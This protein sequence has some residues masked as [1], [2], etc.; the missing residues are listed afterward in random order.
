M[1]RAY[2]DAIGVF[3]TDAFS[4]CLALF[5]GVLVL[6]LGAHG[7]GLSGMEDLRLRDVWM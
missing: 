5:E 7:A 2:G 4:F 6:E 3:L 1:G